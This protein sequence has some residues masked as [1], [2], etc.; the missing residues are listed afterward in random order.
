M[1]LF[2]VQMPLQ[3]AAAFQDR[4]GE[5]ARIYRAPGRVNLIGEHTDYNGGFVLPAAINLS[6]WVG[7]AARADR[8]LVVYSENFKE[9]VEVELD[10]IGSWSSNGWAS[11]P[12]G[13]AW[14]LEQAGQRLRG[15]NLYVRGDVP[16][17]AGLSSSA[18][19]EVATALALLENSARSMERKELAL[20]CQRA[21]NEFVGAR[22]GIMDQ[23]IACHGQVGHAMLLDCRS[24][25]W[26]PVPLPQNA[27]LVVCNSMVKHDLA[28]NEYNARRA[29]CEEGVNK[30]KAVLPAIHSLRDVSIADLEKHRDLLPEMIFRRCRHVVTENE[31]VL[32]TS[33]AFEKGDT[34]AIFEF[35]AASHASLRDDYEVSCRELDVLV[36][37]ASSQEGVL[38]ARMTGGGFGGCTVNLVQKDSVE[39]F[40]SKLKREYLKR[41]GLQS[42]VYLL[43]AAQGAQAVTEE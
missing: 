31:R 22:C 26:R 40:E 12:L 13:V 35:M 1:F 39:S 25:Q 3:L 5:K 37:I 20:L 32:Q 9:Q 7:I 8:K 30:L 43:E 41:T 10:A 42:E 11:Y 16:L 15:A 4:F 23:F 28:V 38:G 34:T 17:G 19:I 2:N 33:A 36:E 21:E 29:E 18:A 24:L 27:A 14:S 6:C